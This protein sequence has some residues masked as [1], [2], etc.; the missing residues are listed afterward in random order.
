MSSGGPPPDWAALYAK[1]KDKMWSVA[2]RVL[3]EAGRESETADV[4]Q[5]AMRS[6][7]ASP[8]NNRDELG[9][10]DGRHGQAARLGPARLGPG[11]ARRR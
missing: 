9:G 2:R 4:V 3:R 10:A 7:M 6:L 8:P 11:A 1:H 5:E